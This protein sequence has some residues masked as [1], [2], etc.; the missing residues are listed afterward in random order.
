[1]S[2]FGHIHAGGAGFRVD[3]WGAGPFFIEAGGKK[4]RFGDSDRFGPFLCDRHGD[5]LTNELPP[6]RSPFWL[7]HRAWVKQGRR[8]ADDGE[9]CIF[10]PLKPT[11]IRIKPNREIVVIEKGDDGGPCLDESGRRWRSLEA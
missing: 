4:F 5:P 9:T 6:E 11:V 1:M 3:G 8:L 7:A 2:E 10:D